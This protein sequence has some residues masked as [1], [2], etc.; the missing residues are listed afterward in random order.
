MSSNIV[1]FSEVCVCFLYLLIGYILHFIQTSLFVFFRTRSHLI[2]QIDHCGAGECTLIAKIW[3]VGLNAGWGGFNLCHMGVAYVNLIH[4]LCSLRGSG[5][6][7]RAQLPQLILAISIFHQR[8]FIVVRRILLASLDQGWL[9]EN[10]HLP[11]PKI[12]FIY[13]LSSNRIVCTEYSLFSP[14]FLM[15]H[16]CP[17]RRYRWLVIICP[18]L[19]VGGL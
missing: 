19:F 13:F 7:N 2:P 8:Q 4:R 3:W 9:D 10:D 1:A 11:G 16:M 6:K 18:N 14:I 15:F 12:L 17:G 5:S